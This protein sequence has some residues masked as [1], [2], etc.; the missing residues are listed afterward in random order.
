MERILHVSGGSAAKCPSRERTAGNSMCDRAVNVAEMHQICIHQCHPWSW[1]PL[2]S[3]IP[4]PRC[5]DS[6][7]TKK[8]SAEAHPSPGRR[9]KFSHHC[10]LS[11]AP[12]FCCPPYFIRLCVFHPPRTP[13]PSASRPNPPNLPTDTPRAVTRA[14]TTYLSRI[15][16]ES[17]LA[18]ERNPSSSSNSPE[19]VP[20][21]I[22]KDGQR[23]INLD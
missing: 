13:K 9:S 14:R 11:Q 12:R 5:M 19:H 8:S 21:L 16:R 6:P 17:P 23:K 20:V 4:L 1:M 7:R 22:R 3:D 18:S 10:P 2:K 15:C